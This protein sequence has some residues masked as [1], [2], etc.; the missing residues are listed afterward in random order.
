MGLVGV[1]MIG[2]PVG[3]SFPPDAALLVQLLIGL[4][5]ALAVIWALLLL[6]FAVLRPKGV[7]LADAARLMPDLIV[8]AGGLARDRSLP[9]RVRVRLWLLLGFMASPI[10]LIPDVIPVI[11]MADD[12]ILAYFVLRRLVRA[13][14]RDV[15]ARHWRGSPEALAA[16][17]RLLRCHPDDVAGNGGD[18]SNDQ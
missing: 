5:V 4:V 14:G 13:A 11:G 17:E 18:Q 9:R 7:V 10:D 1:V 15:L 16:V 3:L 12:V 6:T 2:S 8:L